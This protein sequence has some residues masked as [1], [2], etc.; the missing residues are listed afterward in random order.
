M[1]KKMHNSELEELKEMIVEIILWIQFK[2]P[3][4]NGCI[5]IIT[6]IMRWTFNKYQN[7]QPRF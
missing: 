2:S 3:V 7:H 4:T 6:I 1:E 5:I